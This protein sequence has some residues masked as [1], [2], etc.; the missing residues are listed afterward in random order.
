MFG[1]AFHV[2]LAAPTSAYVSPGLTPPGLSPGGRVVRLRALYDDGGSVS[3]EDY[4][5]EGGYCQ[6]S[7][8]TR[9]FGRFKGKV[10]VVT[11]SAGNF[12][13]AIAERF[14]EEGAS[15]AL[16]DLRSSED[17]RKRLAAKTTSTAHQVDV[18]DYDAVLK[19]VDEVLEAHGRIDY[20]ANNAG[21]QGDFTSVDQYDVKDWAKV[22]D[23]NVNGMFH[24]L[25]AVA[26]A[27]KK[28]NGGVIVQTASMAGHSVPPNMPAY[29]TS[30]AAVQA[31]TIAASKDLSPFNIRV[32]SVSPAFIGPGVLWTRQIDLQAQAGS[33]YYDPDPNIVKSQMINATPLRRYGTLDE[34]VGPILFLFSDDASYLTGVDIQITGGIN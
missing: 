8:E 16:F 14:A 15:V 13:E 19:A 17:L 7:G 25:K 5:V 29:A 32:N 3:S 24:C 9:A 1:F 4:A 28:T 11:G 20:L 10:A 6:R 12:G 26:N 22:M 18:T 33:I 30:K 31:M 34:V 2:I 21:Y 27:M 23:I